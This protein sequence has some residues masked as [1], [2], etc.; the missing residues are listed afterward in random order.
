MTKGKVRD[1]AY[2]IFLIPSE[3]LICRFGFFKLTL[4]TKQGCL[5]REYFGKAEIIPCEPD[6]DNTDEGSFYFNKV[7]SFICNIFIVGQLQ[8]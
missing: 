3:F 6:A 1:I 7:C 8:V 4:P 5:C 2:D